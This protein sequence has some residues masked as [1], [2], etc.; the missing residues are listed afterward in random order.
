MAFQKIGIAYH[1]L[2]NTALKL[3]EELASFLEERGISNWVCSAWKETELKAKL[4]GSDLVLTT[5]GDGTILRVAQAAAG[6]A[7]PITGINLGKL[8]FMTEIE[9][10]E[11]KDRLPILLES[12]GWLD[13][14]AM[15]KAEIK[16]AQEGERSGI[17][18]ALNDAV[19]ARG[20]IARIIHIEASIDGEPLTT[21]RADGL[22]VATATGSTGYSLSAGGPVLHPQSHH[23]LL[24]P[25]MPHLSPS[26]C[27]VLESASEVRMKVITT[28]QATLCIDG[29]IHHPLSS[30]DTI[31]V[32]QSSKRI[33][34]L[35]IRPR[36][37]FYRHLE[38][39][40]KGK[41]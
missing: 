2:N 38:Q 33:N 9:A 13:E 17:F 26:H 23:M 35:R 25:I 36:N 8:G 29:H 41:S 15:L 20:S 37:Y 11:A 14:R 7:I 4:A 31:S 21:Y 5:G 16:P 18:Y 10:R 6:Q 1:P 34:F 28:H 3:A 19:V 39:R 22:V 32:K 40:L 27:L 24:T 30:G 12:Q